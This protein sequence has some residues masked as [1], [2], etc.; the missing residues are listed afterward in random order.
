MGKTKAEIRQKNEG[1]KN[2]EE[3]EGGKGYKMLVTKSWEGVADELETCT[4]E[5]GRDAEISILWCLLF[6]SCVSFG[7]RLQRKGSSMKPNP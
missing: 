2:G 5:T 4:A 1:Q 6:S 7:H 3:R